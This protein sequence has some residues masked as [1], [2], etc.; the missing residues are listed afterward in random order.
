MADSLDP[1]NPSGEQS[2]LPDQQQ[3]TVQAVDLSVVLNYLKTVVPALLEEDNNL[4]PSLEALLKEPTVLEK[5]RKFISDPQTKSF[6]IQRTSVKGMFY[7]QILL[8]I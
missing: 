4:H 1:S 8:L 2:I 7:L 3:P 5:V 6:L